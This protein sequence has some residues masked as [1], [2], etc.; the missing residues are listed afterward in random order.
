MNTAASSW[1]RTVEVPSHDG[2]TH[3]WHLVDRP[4]VGS[5]G[6]TV[7][8]LHG[9]PT[10]S[11]LWSRLVAELAPLHRVIA[12]DQLSMGWSDRTGPRRYRDRVLDVA[13]LLDALDVAGPVWIVAQDWGGA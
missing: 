11:F 2:G 3:R 9:N 12:P 4:P 1:S 8:C 13:D 5:G 7:L 6:A 10:W